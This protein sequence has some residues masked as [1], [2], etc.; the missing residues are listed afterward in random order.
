MI[1]FSNSTKGFYPDSE[2]YPGGLPPD[3]IELS[4]EEYLRATHLNPG[5]TLGVIKGKLAIIPSSPL[6]PAVVKANKW[7]AIKAERDRRIQSGGYKVGAKWFHSDTFSRTQ[8]MGL[9][10]MGA[11]IPN[12]T[13]WKTMDGSTVTMTQTLAG[14]NL[15]TAAA[16]D[17]AIFSAAEIHRVAMEASADPATY[18]FSTGWPKAFGE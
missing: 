3:L 12:G 13:P 16:S 10:M 2:E 1:R 18:D 7:N 14:Q 8:Q 11:N 4:D 17:I 9:V 5:E 6:D 15:G